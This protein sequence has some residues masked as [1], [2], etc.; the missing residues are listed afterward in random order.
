MRETFT[1]TETERG[2]GFFLPTFREEGTHG[3][4]VAHLDR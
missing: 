4:A 1:T 2:K 3:T